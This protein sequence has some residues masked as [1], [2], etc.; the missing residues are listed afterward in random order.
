M[1]FAD[2]FL[3]F[4]MSGKMNEANLIAVL[5][6]L[7]AG[8]NEIMCHPGFGDDAARAR[9]KWNYMWDDEAA[10]LQSESIRQTIADRGI[11]LASFADAWG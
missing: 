4:G 5:D 10:A 2:R 9:Y 6:R 3:G 7:G 1:R 11:R 8:V